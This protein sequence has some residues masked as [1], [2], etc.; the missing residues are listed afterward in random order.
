MHL[1][2]LTP[3]LAHTMHASALLPHTSAPHFCPTGLRSPNA[4]DSQQ[5]VPQT[6]GTAHRHVRPDLAAAPQR[7]MVTVSEVDIPEVGVGQGVRRGLGNWHMRFHCLGT[8]HGACT[9][10]DKLTRLRLAMLGC[11]TERQ[12]HTQTF[13]SILRAA[14][15]ALFSQSGR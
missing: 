10:V 12:H 8:I 15:L 7:P 13:A 3:S 14:Q 2:R 11:H 1:V 6:P 9:E 5:R 4:R